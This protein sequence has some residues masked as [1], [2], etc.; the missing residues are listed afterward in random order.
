MAGGIAHQTEFATT[1]HMRQSKNSEETV[2]LL[3]ADK[4]L[5]TL[6]TGTLTSQYT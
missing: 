4:R 6:M 2:D 5:C 3:V 1:Q